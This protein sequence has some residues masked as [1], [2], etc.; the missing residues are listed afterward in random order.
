MRL[1]RIEKRR[2]KGKGEEVHNGKFFKVL[3]WTFGENKETTIKSKI[4]L[5]KEINFD[6]HHIFDS[7]ERCLEQFTEHEIVEMFTEQKRKSFANGRKAKI[8][9][10]INALKPD[11]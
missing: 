9:E 2:V 3:F 8:E 6:G 4:L 11:E 5:E 7:E 1:K 10:I